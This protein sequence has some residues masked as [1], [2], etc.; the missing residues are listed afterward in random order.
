MLGGVSAPLSDLRPLALGELIDRSATFWRRNFKAL[1]LLSLGFNL[2]SYILA[3]GLQLALQESNIALQAAV[4]DNDLAA[5]GAEYVRLAA[6]LGGVMFFSLWL[7]YLNNLVV[8]RYTVPLQ[9]GEPVRPADGL[10]R[11]GKRLGALTGAYLLSLLWALGAILLMMLPGTVLTGIGAVLAFRPGDAGRV[12][13]AVLL[14]VGICLVGLGF[15]GGLLWYLLRFSL[16]APVLA[17]EDH[18]MRRAFRRSGELLSGRIGPGFTGRVTVRVMLLVTVLS[19]VLIAVNLLCGLPA[20]LLQFIYG[21]PFD[22]TAGVARV[23]NTLLIP[24]ELLQVVGQAVFSPLGLVV[25][26][27]LYLDMRVRREG[28]D[29]ERRLEARSPGAAP[30]GP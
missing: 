3:K 6:P 23:P 5:I 9:L 16:L 17:L 25:Y 11:A 8:A 26:S 4:R 18:P 24:A 7:Y 29:L 10:Q 27:M 1:F 19:L 2:V 28:L 21:N 30:V 14:V 22:P 15:L 13:G 12:V 20:L